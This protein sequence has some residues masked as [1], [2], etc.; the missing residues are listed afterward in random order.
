MTSGRTRTLHF[1]LQ[2]G[3]ELGLSVSRFDERQRRLRLRLPKV[4][5]CWDYA[6]LIDIIARE[7]GFEVASY[8]GKTVSRWLVDW[9][10][11]DSPHCDRFMAWY[12]GVFHRFLAAPLAR[13][14]RIP[15]NHYAI[16]LAA[17]PL[18][19]TLPS[20]IRQKGLKRATVEHW[21]AT[22]NALPAKGLRAEELSESGA[23]TRLHWLSTD[24]VLSQAEVLALIDLR[25]V[26]P[27]LVSESRFGF[28]AQ[29]GWRECCQRIPAK[30]FKR[31]GLLGAGHG[32]V[33]IRFRHRSLGWSVVRTRYRDLIEERTDWWSVL[34]DRGRMV[35]AR[36]QG[37]ESPDAAIEYA[38]LQISRRFHR[39]GRDRPLARWEHFSL[40]G[41]DGY[42]ELLVQ[43]D[44]W[45]GTYTPRHYRTRNVLVHIRTSMRTTES[46]RRVLFLDEIQSDWHAD[47]HA[48]A[49]PGSGKRCD[50]PPPDAPFRKEWPLLS[51]KLMVWWAQRLGADG[52]AW[53]DAELQRER[54]RGYGPP[55]ALYRT[56][57]PEA[58]RAIAKT[59][60]LTFETTAVCVRASD[61]QVELTRRGWEV[62]GHEGTPITKP[63]RSRAQAERFADQTGHFVAL[64]LPVIW[65]DGL[66][67]L[68]AVPLYGT[69]NPAAWLS[70]SSRRAGAGPI[71]I[72]RAE[73]Q[74]RGATHAA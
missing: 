65:I 19:P 11:R 16:E 21:L 23:L 44:D 28:R 32:V 52:L 22:L 26:V 1:A 41:G 42:R 24:A 60:G 57:L 43:I 37:F 12:E 74:A 55:E 71:A 9:Q 51:M 66:D 72:R 14:P 17:L 54:W 63:F 40:P 53:S 56:V 35:T 8:T 18:R 4:A 61:R 69:S 68:T 58:A 33:H 10:A 27:K 25:H 6:P 49:K 50:T 48:E 70:N 36:A 2:D 73:Q 7:P 34:D 5:S 59:L 20:L 47:L 3:R 45:M 38:E 13:R 15:D 46:G 62:S 29:A 31:R 64:D 30:E 67:L 39:W